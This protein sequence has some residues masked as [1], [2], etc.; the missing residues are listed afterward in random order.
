M[1]HKL[2]AIHQPNFFPW[3]GYF[4]KL[5][6]ADVFVLLDDAQFPKKGGT[7]INRV[8]LLVDEEP[9]WVTAPVDRS[10]HGVRQI[11]EMRIDEQRPWRRKLLATIQTSYGRAPHKDEVMPLLSE[12]IENPT[13][14]LAD[15]N[16]TSITALADGLGLTT[17]FVLSSSLGT[18]GRATERL[19]ELVKA[20][21]GSSYLSG[22]GAGGYQ[23]DERFSEAGIELVEQ[24]FEPAT[25]PQLARDPVPG[26]SVIDALLNCGFEGTR[27]L[28]DSAGR[29]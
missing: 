6:R 11:R 13:D 4:D 25:Y 26:L 18:S 21:G 22:G 29:T 14:R 7:W 17:E 3:L 27:R 24:R 19:I 8:R 12:L 23:E 20:V 28:L 10:Y 5:A 2:V 9:A 15:Y 16:R 1:T